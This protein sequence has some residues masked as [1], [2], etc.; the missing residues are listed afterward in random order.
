MSVIDIQKGFFD[1]FKTPDINQGVQEY[2]AI[3]GAVLLDVRM[4]QE[5][6]EGHI[7][8]SKNVPLQSIE[9]A[10]SVVKSKNSPV[11]YI[12][13]VVQEVVR[14]LVLCRRWDMRM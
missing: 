4:P 7:P 9:K 2:K 5:Y 13:T 8:K 12:A 10:L 6:R 14:Q 1:F 11:L 3:P